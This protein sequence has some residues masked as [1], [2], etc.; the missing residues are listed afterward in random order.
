MLLFITILSI[1]ILVIGWVFLTKLKNS[2]PTLYELNIGNK[3]IFS[4][5][6]NEALFIDANV[7]SP[8]SMINIKTIEGDYGDME[9]YEVQKLHMN[10]LK[11]PVEFKYAFDVSH[12]I[13]LN[14]VIR[15]EKEQFENL[16]NNSFHFIGLLS[17]SGILL[18]ANETALNAASA[19]PNDVIG[20]NFWDTPWWQHSLHEQER[21]KDAIER[22]SFG[23]QVRIETNNRTDDGTVLDIDLVLR[24]LL[25]SDNTVNY[26]IV[27]GHNITALKENE[28][29]LKLN[30]QRLMALEELNFIDWKSIKEVN[31]SIMHTCIQ[32]TESSYGFFTTFNDDGEILKVIGSSQFKDPVKDEIL[33]NEFKH[34]AEELSIPK[35]IIHSKHIMFENELDYFGDTGLI[36]NRFIAVPVIQELELTGIAWVINKSDFYDE[37]DIRQ[38]SLLIEEGSK[39]IERIVLRERMAKANQELEKKVQER[40]AE[41]S[42]SMEH[43]VDTQ[44]QLLKSERIAA[45]GHLI[46]NVSHQL[47][48]PIGISITTLSFLTGELNDLL[49]KYEQGNMSYDDLSSLK[50]PI[51]M[52]SDSLTTASNWLDKLKMISETRLTGSIESIVLKDFIHGIY[53]R[54]EM[55]TNCNDV[56]FSLFVSNSLTLKIDSHH[57]EL[58][59]RELIENSMIHGFGNQ[60]HKKIHITISVIENNLNIAYEDNG[61]GMDTEKLNNLIHHQFVNNEKNKPWGLG[62][63]TLINTIEKYLSGTISIDSQVNQGFSC[64]ISIPLKESNIIV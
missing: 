12:F 13:H 56:E 34:F 48:T 50:E 62:L 29:L 63:Q 17:S 51:G 4:N 30:Q 28:K 32:L 7:S 54:L 23:E 21:L 6:E 49:M 53:N 11:I 24:P 18:R 15:N 60:E 39:I 16:Y 47:N 40:T 5:A 37:Y 19:T 43:L 61:I 14:E 46:M 42:K 58:I 64:L 59:F 44:S 36:I 55:D 41:L 25:D 31:T 52:I 22:A 1:L 38:L 3:V 26:I 8:L 35:Q 2:I 57:Y 45:T 20:Q 33:L 9:Y 27:E 10:F